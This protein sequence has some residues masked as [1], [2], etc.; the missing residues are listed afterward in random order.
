MCRVGSILCVNRIAILRRVY[1]NFRLHIDARVR[2]TDIGLI[3]TVIIV[4]DRQRGLTGRKGVKVRRKRRL[5]CV[6]DRRA[7]DVAGFYD[8]LY[9]F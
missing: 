5:M 1:H 6:C 3:E 9:V 8:F 4:E 2:R 7:N